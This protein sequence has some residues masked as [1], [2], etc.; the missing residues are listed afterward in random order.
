[1]AR[2]LLQSDGLHQALAERFVTRY[3]RYFGDLANRNLKAEA[4]NTIDVDGITVDVGAAVATRTT[5]VDIVNGTGIVWVHAAAQWQTGIAWHLADMLTAG[6]DI[7]TLFRLEVITKLTSAL[8]TN[9]YGA[10]FN[11]INDPVNNNAVG[12]V[13]ERLSSVDRVMLHHQRS[14]VS[15]Q[16]F[17]NNALLNTTDPIWWEFTMKGHE[18]SIRYE[19]NRSTFQGAGAGSLLGHFGYDEKP[20][21]IGG[22]ATQFDPKDYNW[23][24][25]CSGITGSS[26]FTVHFLGM[27]L[28]EVAN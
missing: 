8:S 4:G 24:A 6:A 3:S 12:G 26:E 17:V 20:T 11:Y 14:A 15:T 22:G 5:S 9:H 21:P 16:N 19:I 13:Y 27:R 18:A 23:N 7:N 1:M 2:A 10:P 25:S 28:Q